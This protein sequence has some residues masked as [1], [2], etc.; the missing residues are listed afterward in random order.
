MQ[1]MQMK[2]DEA[3]AQSQT[4]SNENSSF[5]NKC[6]CDFLNCSTKNTGG[7][8]TRI[9]A[10]FVNSSFYSLIKFHF[11]LLPPLAVSWSICVLLDVLPPGSASTRPLWRL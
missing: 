1:L 9:A 11:W 10:G 6:K 5:H 8:W 2:G 3:D 4:D 7:K